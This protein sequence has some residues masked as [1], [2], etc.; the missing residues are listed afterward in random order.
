MRR[1]YAFVHSVIDYTG[2]WW[3]VVFPAFA[4]I[5]QLFHKSWEVWWQMMTGTNQSPPLSIMTTNKKLLILICPH[6]SQSEYE[7][8][9]SEGTMLSDKQRVINPLIDW[10]IYSLWNKK[11]FLCFHLNYIMVIIHQLWSWEAKSSVLYK[12]L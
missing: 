12:Y 2:R 8:H 6:V 10:G 4:T 11:L 9:Q 7:R 1:W 5:F 3:H